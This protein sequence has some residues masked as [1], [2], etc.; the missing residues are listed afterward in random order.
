M[1]Y[2][3]CEISEIYPSADVWGFSL[4]KKKRRVVVSEGF[5]MYIL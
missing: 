3:G 1:V 4:V 2:M 5:L